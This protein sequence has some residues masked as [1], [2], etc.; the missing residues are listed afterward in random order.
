MARPK[1]YR[2]NGP[3][4]LDILKAKRI[5]LSGAARLCKDEDGEPMPLTT[6]S[7]LVNDDHG[8]S[9]KTVRQICDGLDLND[10]GVFAELS[11]KWEYTPSRALKA[12]G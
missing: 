9:I 1:G 3:V 8:A 6:L 10:I 11:G 4:F 12:V 5:D 2:L 7:G